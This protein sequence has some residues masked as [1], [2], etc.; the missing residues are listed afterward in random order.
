MIG[1]KDVLY[2]E[3]AKRFAQEYLVKVEVD[4]VLWTKKFIDPLT[5]D[6]WIMDFPESGLHG[7]GPE[8]LRRIRV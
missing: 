7:G 2:G 4:A 6:E 5:G 1:D 3:E 8:R